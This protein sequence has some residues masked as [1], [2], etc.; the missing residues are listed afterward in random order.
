MITVLAVGV[1]AVVAQDNPPEGDQRD[2]KHMEQ[3]AGDKQERIADL[4]NRLSEARVSGQEEE[5]RE[6]QQQL[7]RLRGQ[8]PQPQPRQR[9]NPDR[10]NREY[11]G[12][13]DVRNAELER[14][15]QHIRVAV[16]NL[17]AAG[18]HEPAERLSQEAERIRNEM[19]QR[20]APGQSPVQG[21]LEE[22]RREIRRLHQALSD[23]R[24]QVERLSEGRG[25]P[26]RK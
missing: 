9:L 3:Q 14:R 22:M 6:I 2:A 26:Q 11:P 16:E 17:H 7:R 13:V 24:E 21:E 12:R 25:E 20:R 23:L 19:V 15:L 4:R 1:A 10:P 5:A 18:L 8:D